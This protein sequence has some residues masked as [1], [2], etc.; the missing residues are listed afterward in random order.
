MD[1]GKTS[2]VSVGPVKNLLKIWN[3]WVR[4]SSGIDTVLYKLRKWFR[5]SNI[6]AGYKRKKCVNNVQKEALPCSSFGF[7]YI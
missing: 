7:N 2:L 4:S 1:S 3:I 6:F 5:H